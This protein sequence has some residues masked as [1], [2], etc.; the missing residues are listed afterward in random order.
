[1][2]AVAK[3][4]RLQF[5]A[6]L[7]LLLVS[8][9]AALWLM[10]RAARREA[11]AVRVRSQFITRIGHDL[12][13]PLTL[14][15]MYAETLAAGKVTDA[16][17]A[18]EFAGIAMRE[19]ER[20]S[21]LVA[22]VLDFSRGGLEQ[23][24]PVEHRPIDVNELTASV[25]LAHRPAFEQLG[26]AVTMHAVDADPAPR[27]IGDRDALRGAL[28][29]LLENVLH[30]AAEGRLLE[31]RVASHDGVVEIQVL[32]RGPGL[33]PAV[34]DRL[35]ERFVRGPD[36]SGTG[37]GLGLALVREIAE[38]HGGSVRAEDRHGGGAT[39][40]IVLPRREEA[41]S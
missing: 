35:F 12:R 5:A 1:V 27:V 15:R 29:N 22:K 9:G 13:T 25:V 6:V 3:Q 37:I 32:D 40:T 41:R 33:P 26:I 38:A 20:L 34:R 7:G 18:R 36:A 19:A 39:F 4:R 16:D 23:D 30:H 2:D 28:G 17:Q 14:I 11:E 24:R 21:K 10:Q 8:G 31:A